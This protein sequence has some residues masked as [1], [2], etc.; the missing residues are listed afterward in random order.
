MILRTA[1]AGT[2]R[3]KRW[4]LVYAGGKPPECRVGEHPTGFLMYTPGGY[5]SASLARAMRP[6]LDLQDSLSQVGG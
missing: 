2:W 5:V 3:Q 1:L 6:P 4:E